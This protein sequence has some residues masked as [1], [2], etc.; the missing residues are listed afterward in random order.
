MEN[1]NVVNML[2][3]KPY[4]TNYQLTD[5]QIHIQPHDSIKHKDAEL[6]NRSERPALIWQL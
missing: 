1:E 3:T 5:T 6:K 2:S 4:L